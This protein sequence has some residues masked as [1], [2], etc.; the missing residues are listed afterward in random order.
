MNR[1]RI[2]QNYEKKYRISFNLLRIDAMILT[3]FYVCPKAKQAN[4]EN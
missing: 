3:V 2:L 1:C 4:Y